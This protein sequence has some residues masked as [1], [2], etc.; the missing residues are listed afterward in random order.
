MDHVYFSVDCIVAK[1]YLFHHALLSFSCVFT[2]I[3]DDNIDMSRRAMLL[4]LIA[5]TVRIF[6]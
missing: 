3:Y 4:G 2:I 1:F 5:P 6:K